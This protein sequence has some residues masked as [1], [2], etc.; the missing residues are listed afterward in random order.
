LESSWNRW[1]SVKF[2]GKG[3]WRVAV[4]VAKKYPRVT[5]TILYI[6]EEAE[7]QAALMKAW[8]KMKCY[9]DQHRGDIPEHKVGQKV[10]L[11][12]ENLDLKLPS[13]KLMARQ[14]RP[15]PIVEII[16]LNVVKVKLPGS[17]KIHPVINV[18]R[19]HLKKEPTISGQTKSEPPPVE[20]DGD[21]EYEV[22]QILDSQI[23]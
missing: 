7:A 12:A 1:G 19:L 21:L 14:V 11:E 5:P 15:Y 4:R 23:H 6:Q 9:A 17:I 18:S 8:D 10:W 22:E 2:W 13:K 20:I 16:S 3:F